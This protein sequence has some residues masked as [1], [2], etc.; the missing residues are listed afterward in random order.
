M[1]S[2]ITLVKL[3]MCAKLLQWCLTLH[4][5]ID[6]SSPGSSVHGDSPGKNTRVGCQL[7]LQGIFPTQGLNLSLLSPALAGGFFTARTAVL[8]LRQDKKGLNQVQAE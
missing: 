8:F 3:C 7:L 5:P 2:K 4:S 6:C 1:I